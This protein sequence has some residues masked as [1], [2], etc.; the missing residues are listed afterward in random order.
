MAGYKRL[1]ILMVVLT[2]AFVGFSALMV[3]ASEGPVFQPASLLQARPTATPEKPR[4]TPIPEVPSG[5]GDSD[6]DGISNE[7]DRCPYVGN[8]G[9]GLTG[10]GCPIPLGDATLPPA[11]SNLPLVVLD[12]NGP[13]TV[14]NFTDDAVRIRS[15]PTLE[16]EIVGRLYPNETS[17]EVLNLD[18]SET[19]LRIRVGQLEG[20]VFGEAV[21]IVGLCGDLETP[22]PPPPPDTSACPELESDAAAL[23]AYLKTYL[24]TQEDDC[25]LL[26]DWQA[27]ENQP[28][29]GLNPEPLLLM[30]DECGETM[31]NFLMLVFSWNATQPGGDGV[32]ID[33]LNGY[34][35]S[36]PCT[37]VQNLLIGNFPNDLPDALLKAG[38]VEFC[39]PVS[40]TD[41]RF[42]K[43]VGQFDLLDV[44]TDDLHAL[45]D[46]GLIQTMNLLGDLSDEQ[47]AVFYAGKACGYSDLDALN[48]ILTLLI[49][50]VDIGAIDL[51]TLTC[52]D[53][54]NPAALPP[55]TPPDLP[56]ELVGC[57]PDLVLIFWFNHQPGLDP[58]ALAQLL[59]AANPCYAI[60]VYVGTGLLPDGSGL[61]GLPDDGVIMTL[62]PGITK[63]PPPV[64]GGGYVPAPPDVQ[65]P[66]GPLTKPSDGSETAPELASIVEERIAD[67]SRINLVFQD[68][69]VVEDAGVLGVESNQR[70]PGPSWLKPLNVRGRIIDSVV[71]NSNEWP[72]LY[73]LEED[74]GV[75]RLHVRGIEGNALGVE[76]N[77]TPFRVE[78]G[79][80]LDLV[81]GQAG[82]LISLRDNNNL[83]GIYRVTEFNAQRPK[84]ELLINDARNPSVFGDGSMI[85]FERDVD[86]FAR[87]YAWNAINQRIDLVSDPDVDCISPVFDSV[88]ITT[89]DV[90]FICQ[91][92]GGAAEI[93][94]AGAR[95]QDPILLEGALGL[96]GNLDYALGLLTLD[97]GQ[98]IY[99]RLNTPV[100]PVNVMF[101]GEA[102]LT[103]AQRQARWSIG[104]R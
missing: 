50:G 15:T 64:G 11:Q 2:A 26:K 18:V 79:T 69:A 53:L 63:T 33:T 103:D 37:F 95:R 91:A 77:L 42:D 66:S 25:Q 40:L 78:P 90:Y 65:P 13:C 38:L 27:P 8:Q 97:N 71:D 84:I 56:P 39:T 24:S 55:G 86:G 21:E 28:L 14:A 31:P 10:D 68:F 54:A 73:Y 82:V 20:W 76:V 47:L 4:E 16:G 104:G 96:M 100:S 99:F 7:G 83:L 61:A 52:A 34:L 80:R 57:P 81:P 32:L 36:D 46:C 67:P 93:R 89:I 49:N 75:I 19:W 23:P 58:A 41:A 5:P 45:T 9:Y 3:Q 59:A 70:R 30:S 60:D 43:L 87:V 88:E 29:M 101:A 62:E 51:N 12:P 48:L 92:E 94:Q 85:V 22:E 74:A 1:F 98:Q 102:S 72:V 44:T 6:S 35:S 17:D